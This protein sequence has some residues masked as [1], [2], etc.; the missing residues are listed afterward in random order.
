MGQ[1]ASGD[2]FWQAQRLAIGELEMLAILAILAGLGASDG[3]VGKG[4]GGTPS[5]G[6]IEMWRYRGTTKHAPAYPRFCVDGFGRLW[7]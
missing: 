4:Y 1:A 2:G 6:G 5:F 7:T 3:G